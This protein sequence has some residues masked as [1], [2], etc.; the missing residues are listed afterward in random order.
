LIYS[1]DVIYTYYSLFWHLRLAQS[2]CNLVQTFWIVYLQVRP[3]PSLCDS[4]R[5]RHVL[6]YN[7]LMFLLYFCFR[8]KYKK[9]FPTKF[10][11]LNCGIP[12]QDQPSNVV[13]L[14]DAPLKRGHPSYK[15]TFW[16]QNGWVCKKGTATIKLLIR[17]SIKNV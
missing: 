11:E 6:L 3:A 17:P 2:F 14:N 1:C 4:T 12:E 8:L 7:K 5:F 9:L 13:P 16:L 15:A 10:R